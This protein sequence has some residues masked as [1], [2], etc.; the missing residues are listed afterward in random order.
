MLDAPIPS[1]KIPSSPE[2]FH[3]F[4][5]EAF[6]SAPRIQIR[7]RH[8]PAFQNNSK[9][10]C[11]HLNKT[12]R[13]LRDVASVCVSLLGSTHRRSAEL[14]LRDP[15][16]LP[17]TAPSSFAPRAFALAVPSACGA[18]PLFCHWLVPSYHSRLSVIFSERPPWW[19]HPQSLTF[20]SL[21]YSPL[22]THR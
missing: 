5:L 8:S 22:C 14:A 11:E 13:P 1:S 10:S 12:Y 9:K 6:I 19:C 4:Q 7:S 17:S 16:F 21:L 2:H 3:A 18:L 20:T 15:H